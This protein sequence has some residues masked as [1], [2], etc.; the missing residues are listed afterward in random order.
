M[1]YDAIMLAAPPTSLP[2]QREL[3]AHYAHGRRRR[4]QAGGPLQLP[5]P[6]RRRDRLR[7]PRR[8]RRSSR[9]RRASRSRAATSRGSCI[10]ND[11]YAGRLDDHVRQRRPGG[12]YFAWGV[13]CWLAGTANV[14]PRHHVAIM[15]TANAGD[16]DTARRQFDGDPAVGAEHGE[17]LV[18]LE[19]QARPAASGHRLRRRPPAAAA[20]HRRCRRRVPRR[21]STR[22]SPPPSPS[23]DACARAVAHRRSRCTPRASRARATSARVFDVP[24]ATMR[25]KLRHINEVDDSIRKFLCFEPRGRPQTSANLVFPSP[26]PRGR[27]RVHH[28]PSG[29]RPRD[30]RFEHDL[31]RHRV[32]GDRHRSP[33][34]GARDDGR[35]GDG[36]RAWSRTAQPAATAAASGSRST[37][38]RRSS[39]RSTCRWTCPASA[40]SASTSPTAAATTCSPTRRSSA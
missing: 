8:S 19:G 4:R 14:L 16:H 38:F 32:A 6:R 3:A 33:M 29:P 15:D 35:A 31:R 1:G 24:G 36:R 28:L 5:G 37:A 23:T 34:V 20:P 9:H 26:D 39:R 27:R 12:D 40:T 10:C 2:T 17:R 25:D 13:R 7:V 21:R 18:Q 11:R 22:R 30:E